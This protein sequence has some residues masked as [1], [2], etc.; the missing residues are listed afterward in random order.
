[1][2]RLPQILT[3]HLLNPCNS[4]VLTSNSAAL[5]RGENPACGDVLVLYLDLDIEGNLEARFQ[6]KGCSAVIAVASLITQALQGLAPAE[7]RSLP[8]ESLVTE[9]GGLDRMQSHAIRVMT[10]ALGEALDGLATGS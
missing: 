1:M 4:G 7:A 6:A 5:G 8:I 3:Q 10:R 9:A 2:S